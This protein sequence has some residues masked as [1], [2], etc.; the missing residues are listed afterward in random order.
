MFREAVPKLWKERRYLLICALLA[1]MS[2]LVLSFVIPARYEST[3]RIIP[4]QQIQ[5]SLGALVGQ[6]GAVGF[7]G[8][9]SLRYP[10]DVYVQLLRSDSLAR[11]MINRFLLEKYY[12]SSKYEDAKKRLE[13]RSYIRGS[14]EGVVTV[15][16]TDRDPAMAA[17]LANGYIDELYQTVQR[18]SLE[19]ATHRRRF[20]EGKLDE[21]R[22]ALIAK[23]T[24]FKAMQEKLGVLR[25]D[26]QAENTHSIMIGLRAAIQAKEISLRAMSFW[27]TSG[28]PVYRNT[29]AEIAALKQELRKMESDPG[30]RDSRFVISA[31]RAPELILE[32]YRKFRELKFEEG[33]YQGLLRQYELI[34]MEE[35]KDFQQFLV[36][37]VARPA[38]EAEFPS[39]RMIAFLVAVLGC[40]GAMY[41]V[42]TDRIWYPSWAGEFFRQ[43]LPS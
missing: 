14:R 39:P 2:G 30:V 15:R 18:L 43:D 3:T 23:E 10:S 29:E 4:P 22:S 36:V 1:A 24:D 8:L 7:S 33:L 25:V 20:M 26:G 9:S 17:T 27:A 34:R 11:A 13:S 32:Y 35:A 28:N 31:E 37:D 38:T 40:L 6:M 41:L 12:D 42:S 19:E 21:T 5:S 16:V